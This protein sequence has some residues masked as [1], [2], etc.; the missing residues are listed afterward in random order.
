MRKEIVLSPKLSV[1]LHY[2]NKLP[3]IVQVGLF[4]WD[5]LTAIKLK[6]KSTD[7]YNIQTFDIFNFD[8]NWNIILEFL[9]FKCEK[10]IISC[11]KWRGNAFT[12]LFGFLF[13]FD[14]RTV[15]ILNMAR[16]HDQNYIFEGRKF[17][18]QKLNTWVIKK[19]TLNNQIHHE[20]FVEVI[21]NPVI[22]WDLINFVIVLLQFLNEKI[23]Y[24][25][26]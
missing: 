23:N 9:F 16:F 22:I 11:Q 12:Y 25:W 21:F 2:P 7:W 26:V 19:N 1:E 18:L 24:F 3:E 8:H 6:T 10:E 4:H 14:W 5:L 15:F 13:A 17:I 20:L